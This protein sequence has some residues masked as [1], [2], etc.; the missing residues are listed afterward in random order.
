MY[1]T[2]L[3]FL[4]LSCVSLSLYFILF[5]YV[6]IHIHPLFISSPSVLITSLSLSV[7][8]SRYLTLPLSVSSPLSFPVPCALHHHNSV[9]VLSSLEPRP[10]KLIS[11][12][13]HS[14][15]RLPEPPLASSL[16][17]SSCFITGPSGQNDLLVVAPNL[18]L[19]PP[20]APRVTKL[21]LYNPVRV[22]WT[23]ISLAAGGE[24]VWQ[25]LICSPVTPLKSS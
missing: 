4:S 2:Q 5:F 24:L 22:P 11:Q 3:C 20:L 10:T 23:R 12:P 16:A 21:H 15:A 8:I 1:F 25:H 6:N 14:N 17:T 9:A 18:N 19:P 7:H 13:S